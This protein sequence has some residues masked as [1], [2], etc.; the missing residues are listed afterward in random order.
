MPRRALETRVRGKSSSPSERRPTNTPTPPRS[1]G[2]LESSP[3]N[4][5]ALAGLG[6]SLFSAGAGTVP[7]N[8]AQMQEG[9]NLMTRFAEIAPETHPLKASVKDAVDYLKTKKLEP[10]KTPKAG[11]K[12]T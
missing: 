6:L 10:Q 3:D 2:V 5:D 11:K 7:E 4:P 1:S 8:T 9:L 12:K